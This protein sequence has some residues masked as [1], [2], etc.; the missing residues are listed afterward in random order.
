[1][2][3]KLIEQIRSGAFAE[4]ELINLYKNAQKRHFPEVAEA[5]K[6]QM[7]ARF[8]RTANKLFGKEK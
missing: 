2:H 4:P 6:E 1:M 7:R 3:T 5:A 8:S